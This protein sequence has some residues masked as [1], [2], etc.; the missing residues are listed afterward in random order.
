MTK[1]CSTKVTV[2]PRNGCSSFETESVGPVPDPWLHDRVIYS[3][4][5]RDLPYETEPLELVDGYPIIPCREDNT[6]CP[7]GFTFGDNSPELSLGHGGVKVELPF[8]AREVQVPYIPWTT[9]PIIIEGYNSDDVRIA[10]FTGD[11]NLPITIHVAKILGD[12]IKYFKIFGGD[13]E[14]DIKK[15]C[16][17]YEEECWL[18]IVTPEGLPMAIRCP[19]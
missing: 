14:I 17:Y 4:I 10:D 8:P 9:S 3:R 13:G 19:Q 2:K 6:E 7:G 12:G 18:H 11:E 15:V 1:A 16:F 5:E